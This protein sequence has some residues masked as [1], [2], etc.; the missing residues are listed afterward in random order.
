[1]KSFLYVIVFGACAVG[2]GECMNQYEQNAV[3]NIPVPHLQLISSIST[4]DGELSPR[5]MYDKGSN[6]ILKHETREYGALLILKSAQNGCSDAISHFSLS[7][8]I[9]KMEEYTEIELLQALIEAASRQ[10]I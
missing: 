4:E 9:Q 8:N 10:E 7:C 1:M 5:S 3:S 6:L 2:I